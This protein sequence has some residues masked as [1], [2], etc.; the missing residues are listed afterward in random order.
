M[1]KKKVYTVKMLAYMNGLTIAELAQKADIK[2]SRLYE[3]SAGRRRMMT[4]DL[5][6]LTTVTGIKPEQIAH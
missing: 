5:Y 6:K 3:I 1:A 4:R 2:P